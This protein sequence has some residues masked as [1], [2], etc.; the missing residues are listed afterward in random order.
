MKFKTIA[1]LALSAFLL[2]AST[3]QPEQPTE[4]SLKKAEQ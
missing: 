2:A 3:N 1:T 4:E